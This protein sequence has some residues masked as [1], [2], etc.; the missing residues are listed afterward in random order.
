[1]QEPH[2][3]PWHALRPRDV[4]HRLDARAEG[5][6]SEGE[7]AERREKFGP[8]ALPQ[9]SATPLWLVIARQFQNPFVYILAF[10][11]AVSA[12]LRE[13]SDAAFILAVILLN[14]GIGAAQ[15]WRAETSAAALRRSLRISPTVVR[16]GRRHEVDY[17]ELVPGDIVILQAGAAVPADIRL[18][19]A[20]D[21]DI[22]ESLLTGEA[23]AVRKSEAAAIDVE[24]TVGDR[25]TMAHAGTMV[26]SGRGVGVVCATG[27]ATELGQIA[28]S[29]TAAGGKPPLLLRLERFSNNVAIATVALVLLLGLGQLA[30]G[31]APGEILLFT[32]ALAVSAIPEGLPMAITIAL[33][34]AS[35]RM[36]RRGVIVRLLPAV[37]ALG[38]CT[39][40]ASDKTGTLTVNRLTVKRLVLPDGSVLDVEGEG[41]ELKGALSSTEPAKRVDTVAAAR[42]ARAAALASEADVRASDGT[43][44]V[45][46][47]TV[48]VA[49]LVLA[50]KLGLDR[51]DLLSAHRQRALLP[52]ETLRT[53]SASLNSDGEGAIL[54]VKGAPEVLLRMCGAESREP[55]QRALKTLAR[56]GYRVI[57]I[58]E[59]K[60]PAGS[61]ISPDD[62]QGLEL[63]GF[64]GLIDPL[65]D[66]APAAIVEAREAGVDVRMITGDHPDTALAIARQL[67]PS[68]FPETAL[69]G[70]E[71]ARLEGAARAQ[72]IREAAVFA[73]VEPD[74]KTLIVKELQKQ[75]HFVAV[76]GD[77]V[78]D[79]PALQAAHVGV[80]MGAGGTDVARAASDLVITDDDFAS[81][82]A[83]IEEGRG[84]YAN[85]RKIV[86][87]LVSTAVAE[88][89]MF[90]L[91]LLA[92]LP[93]PLTAAQILWFNL[94]TEGI[95][96]ISLAFER[97]E[98]DAMR[99]KPRR[100]S[101]PIF[102]RQMV[103]Q[104]LL[105]GGFV[106]VMSLGLFAWL[107]LGAGHSEESARNL[108]LLFLVSYSNL[109]VLNCRSET[110]SAFSIPIRANR[111]LI[112]GIV[113]A[114]AVHIAAMHIPL[115]QDVLGLRPVAILDWISVLTLALTVL[116]L[117]EAYKALRARPRARRALTAPGTIAT[118]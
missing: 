51:H 111:L 59:R 35:A 25:L 45:R 47:D 92:A 85:I 1:M 31:D 20:H 74:Q 77:G 49:F 8:N 103:E 81:I 30:R 3:Q 99:R 110:R 14:T 78:N 10:A 117:G 9:A 71:L 50:A 100:P 36:G 38:S 15:E 41:L 54:S 86:W 43:V 18:I 52:Y 6:L 61:E 95:Q 11:V 105:V 33:A 5:G 93:M 7:V 118:H 55:M 26:V 56:D 48:D 57:A 2:A 113:A 112:A 69:T 53:H 27:A 82:V 67:D 64:A 39:L 114:Q 89:L 98:P 68:W 108:T 73:R 75:G 37:E 34:A 97:R 24:A 66:E 21:L 91:A 42:L 13:W 72:A 17:A 107:L 28:K 62:L 44:E 76:T 104:C 65:R 79:A 70:R 46:G 16:A 84:A 116:L 23:E 22:D 115:M 4:L 102:D 60:L 83:G 12:L 96:D 29:L 19:S 109:H 32:I 80:A 58:A 87:F 101:E 88:V 90:M 106:G 94:V 63:L 40:I